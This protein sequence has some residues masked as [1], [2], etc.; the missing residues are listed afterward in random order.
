VTGAPVARRVVVRG[1]VQGVFFRDSTRR[2]AQAEGVA[3]WVRNRS[4]GAVEAWFEGP[5]DAVERLV[6]FA[7]RG[8]RGA[9]VE[10]VE[11]VDEEPSGVG[12]FQV[13]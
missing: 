11:V 8:P 2:R 12:G 9:A 7:R 1:H 5:A 3:G 13:R 10:S 6:A 4:D